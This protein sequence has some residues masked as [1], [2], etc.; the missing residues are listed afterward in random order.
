M[1]FNFTLQLVVLILL[2][3]FFSISAKKISRNRRNAV[4]FNLSWSLIMFIYLVVVAPLTSNDY[5][6]QQGTIEKI[7]FL[8]LNSKKDIVRNK[9]ADNF[10]LIDVSFDQSIITNPEFQDNNSTL[11]ITDRKKLNSLLH[12]LYEN[13]EKYNLA[14]LDV[15]FDQ[16]DTSHDD[17]LSSI[18]SELVNSNKLLLAR[19][20]QYPNIL[21][22][23][24]INL[25]ETE[26]MGDVST[27]LEGGTLVYNKFFTNPN[28]GAFNSLPFLVYCKSTQTNSS[29]INPFYIKNTHNNGLSDHAFNFFAPIIGVT[30]VRTNEDHTDESVISMKSTNDKTKDP[31]IVNRMGALTGENSILQKQFY[32]AQLQAGKSTNSKIIFI[33]SF[34][35]AEQDIHK[36]LFGQVPG[37]LIIVNSIA[38]L[39]LGYHQT[40]LKYFVFLFGCLLLIN[41]VIIIFSIK[42]P[43]GKNIIWRIVNLITRNE[44]YGII[45][46]T[47]KVLFGEFHY[48]VTFI[49]AYVSYEYFNKP[50]NV[51]TLLAI[52]SLQELTFKTMQDKKEEH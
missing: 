16:N 26:Y 27:E 24:R 48:W 33:G 17:S 47:K 31:I 50:T 19:S 38:N 15:F 46:F 1:N 49:A 28:G 45:R 14:V 51:M 41:F 52:F 23:K 43:A 6:T 12:F 9:I 20:E 22:Y 7:N 25:A 18:I 44:K 40:N 42:N 13:K 10:S 5:S 35:N 3:I 37:S 39:L 32:L 21:N 4:L 34:L 8:N 29:Y 36:T 30:S 11:C 2:F